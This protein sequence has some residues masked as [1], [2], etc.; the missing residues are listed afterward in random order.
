M[1]ISTMTGTRTNIPLHNNDI[2]GSIAKSF[3]NRNLGCKKRINELFRTIFFIARQ[4]LHWPFSC[5]KQMHHISTNKSFPSS[6]LY[7][8]HWLTHTGG[9]LETNSYLTFSWPPDWKNQQVLLIELSL[10]RDLLRT[11]LF[12]GAHLTWPSSPTSPPCFWSSLT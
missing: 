4:F 11:E 12:S 3:Q 2:Q 8:A 10:L 9:I 7:F 6:K 1:T 5:G